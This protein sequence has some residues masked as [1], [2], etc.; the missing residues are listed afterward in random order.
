MT[1]S[2]L[3]KIVDSRRQQWACHSCGKWF[4]LFYD[5]FVNNGRVL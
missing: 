5:R 4:W 1:F 3:V 2:L